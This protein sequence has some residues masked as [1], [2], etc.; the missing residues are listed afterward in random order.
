MWLG[1]VAGVI[2]LWIVYCFVRANIRR[3]KLLNEALRAEDERFE[4]H[5]KKEL[6]DI[7]QAKK[8]SEA[9]E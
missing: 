4:T 2:A 7:E 6:W 5:R 1:L 9:T 8:S 3:L